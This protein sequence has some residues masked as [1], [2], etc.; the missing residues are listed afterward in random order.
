MRSRIKLGLENS[1]KLLSRVIELKLSLLKWL[2]NAL[3]K[4][5]FLKNGKNKT[6]RSVGSEGNVPSGFKWSV[7]VACLKN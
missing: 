3:M 6:R 5:F 2:L 7:L 4:F 1:A